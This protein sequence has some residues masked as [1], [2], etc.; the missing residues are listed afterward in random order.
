MVGEISI[1]NRASMPAGELFMPSVHEELPSRIKSYI[2]FSVI[3]RHEGQ[4]ATL[5][6]NTKR[7]EI[8]QTW[9][10]LG[11]SNTILLRIY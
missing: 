7:L 10:I 1:T 3:Y 2:S 4:K 8:T 11:N 5:H 9:Y 6:K